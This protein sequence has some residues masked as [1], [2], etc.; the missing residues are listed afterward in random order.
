MQTLSG[1]GCRRCR[2]LAGPVARLV[3]RA[4]ARGEPA[5]RSAAGPSR[6]EAPQTGNFQLYSEVGEDSKPVFLMDGSCN[7]IPK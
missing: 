1:D 5:W 2:P 7:Y 3:A 6:L 4:V